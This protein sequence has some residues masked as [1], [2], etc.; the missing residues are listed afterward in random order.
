MAVV[1]EDNSMR[2]K[3]AINQ[4]GIG[5]LYEA[6]G[7]LEAQVKRNT[8]VDTGQTKGS[9]EYSVNEDEGEAVIGSAYENAIWEE[10]GTGEY[11]L[12]HD[13]RNKPW[14]YKD[15]HGNWHTT[16]GKKPRRALWHA[17]TSLKSQLINSADEKFGGLGK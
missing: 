3:E 11:A 7:E 14:V 17:Y 1:F 13:G 6:A 16:R 2:V 4:C 8:K 10:F 9:W 5:W 15:V 12:N